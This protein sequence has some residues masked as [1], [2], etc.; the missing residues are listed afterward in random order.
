MCRRG[1]GHPSLEVQAP[2]TNI[3][4]DA[5]PVVS[6]SLLD[7]LIP[8]GVEACHN[9]IAQGAAVRE[10]RVRGSQ[11][12]LTVKS[13]GCPAPSSDTLSAKFGISPVWDYREHQRAIKRSQTKV[14]ALEVAT[15]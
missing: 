4:D 7:V 3:L 1:L 8:P 12:S 9:V 2:P 10:I 13:K 15:G 6:F 5:V 14:Y 11:R